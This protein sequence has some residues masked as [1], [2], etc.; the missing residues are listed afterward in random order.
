MLSCSELM[1]IT[2]MEG[3]DYN[4][5]CMLSAAKLEGQWGGNCAVGETL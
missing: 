3:H 5:C 1:T 4:T 2:I